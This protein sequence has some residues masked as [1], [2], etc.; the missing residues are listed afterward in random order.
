[1]VSQTNIASYGLDAPPVIRNLALFGVA[2]IAAGLV[3]RQLLASASPLLAGILL[4]WGLLA[5]ASLLITAGLMIWSSRFGKLRA[6]ERLIDALALHGDEQVLDAGCGRGLLLNA[7]ARRLTIGMATGLDLW[8]RED[9]SGNDPAV[10][11]ANAR[12]EGVADRVKLETGDMR[13]MPFDDAT[14]DVVVSSLALHNIPD[15]A[16]RAQA[17]R[18]IARVLKPGG[19][20]ALLDFQH[21][22]EYAQVLRDLSWAGVALSGPQLLMFPPVRVVAARKPIG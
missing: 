20:V 8:R 15:A 13:R 11:L 7:A 17:V 3:A 4:I 6:R 18:E 9:Q 19:R 12:A 1:M 21:T 10:T 14:F 16:G 22:G 2:S 5:G